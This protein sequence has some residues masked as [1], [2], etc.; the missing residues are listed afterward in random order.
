MTKL[1]EALRLV[2]VFHDVSQTELASKLKISKSYLSEIEA[3][4]KPASI[5]L[6]KKYSK[7]FKVPVSSLMLFSETLESKSFSERSRVVIAGKILK[8][9]NWLAAKEGSGN[10]KAA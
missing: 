7:I 10:E 6:L 9:M 8:I 3:G 2:R 1:H 4:K 5:E